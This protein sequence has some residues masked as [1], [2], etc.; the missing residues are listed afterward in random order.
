M[1]L[2]NWIIRKLHIHYFYKP[3]ASQ[4]VSFNTRRIIFECS[5]GKRKVMDEVRNFGEPFSM[6]TNILITNQEMLNI[7]NKI[8]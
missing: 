6:R 5:C 4:Y 8:K 1:K 2:L 7:L 3:I